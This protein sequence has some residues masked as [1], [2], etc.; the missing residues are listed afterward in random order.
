LRAHVASIAVSGVEKILMK[1]IDAKA[2]NALLTDL[3]AQI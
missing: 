1:E 3:A 2:H